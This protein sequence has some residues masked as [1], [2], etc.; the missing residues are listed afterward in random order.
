MNRE[1]I[2]AITG[3][4][5]GSKVLDGYMRIVDQWVDHDNVLIGL[6]WQAQHPNCLTFLPTE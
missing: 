3:H 2:S 1:A 5:D 4:G 6:M